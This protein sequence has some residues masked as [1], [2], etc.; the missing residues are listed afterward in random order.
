MASQ[1]TET[2]LI[3]HTLREQIFLK[4]YE[5]KE[6]QGKEWEKQHEI[7]QRQRMSEKEML[8]KFSRESPEEFY[9]MVFVREFEHKRI[10]DDMCFTLEELCECTDAELEAF[11]EL[12]FRSAR[13]G[14]RKDMF[15]MI[16]TPIFG[17]ALGIVALLTCFSRKDHWS[18]NE[19]YYLKYRKIAR[20]KSISL[21]SVIREHIE[22]KRKKEA[23]DISD[24]F[25]L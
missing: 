14:F 11:E 17:W 19:Y 15:A 18:L 24:T 21:V 1:E 7:T 2:A 12:V 23:W 6:K 8:K 4:I 20:K 9:K 5:R 25:T 13:S 22:T 16:F 3:K 10:Y